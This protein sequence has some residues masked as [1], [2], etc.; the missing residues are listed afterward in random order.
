MCPVRCVSR[1]QVYRVSAC[2]GVMDSAELPRPKTASRT[3]ATPPAFGSSP[4]PAP[5]AVGTAATAASTSTPV[6]DSRPTARRGGPSGR[7]AGSEFDAT[8]SPGKS[9]H[10]TKLAAGGEEGASTPPHPH[11]TKVA[12][13]STRAVGLSN[14]GRSASMD[15]DVHDA[16][17]PTARRGGP[18]SASAS[19]G[20]AAAT[21][22]STGRGGAANVA[23][24]HVRGSGVKPSSTG[25]G[26]VMGLPLAGITALG[27]GSGS[28]SGGK[29]S[30]GKA[31]V[32]LTPRLEA[33]H[34]SAA[35]D[36]PAYA[37][38]GDDRHAVNRPSTAP[39]KGG[40]AST[41]HLSNGGPTPC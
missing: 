13:G 19:R 12:S 3:T 40:R 37:S 25:V 41:C 4:A 27:S 32:S 35:V 39:L 10:H 8:S 38:A 28:G 36:V 22:T 20:G 9:P 1:V 34:Q 31:G 29:S 7:V 16:S 5:V 14:V 26:A 30:Q 18:G 2:V 33:K 24:M 6:A 21:S 17:R 15:D 23:S 11:R